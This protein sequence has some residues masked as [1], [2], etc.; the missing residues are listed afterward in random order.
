[1][2]AGPSAF[3]DLRRLMDWFESLAHAPRTVQIEKIVTRLGV[4]CVPLLGRELAGVDPRRREAARAALA[5]LASCE[6]TRARVIAELQRVAA[7][8]A[9][10]DGKV[11]ALGLLAELGE[12]GAAQF[13]DGPAVQ[14]RSA[15][16]LAAQLDTAGDVAAA[17]DMMVRQLGGTD[18]VNLMG[19]LAEAAPAAAHRLATELV[20]RLDLD[21]ELRERIA[22]VAQNAPAPDS[23]AA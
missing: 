21:G 18:V 5:S 16:A 20:A 13:V 1:M 15:L 12:R 22:E 9:S 19:V 4:R 3:V 8:D 17:A 2:E 23:R 11:C 14:R 6:D 7:G 10:D